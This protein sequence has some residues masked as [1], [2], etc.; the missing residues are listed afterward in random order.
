MISKISNGACGACPAGECSPPPSL[1]CAVYT[2]SQHSLQLCLIP[3]A[4]PVSAPFPHPWFVQCTLT[5]YSLLGFSVPPPAAPAPALAPTASLAPAPA[6]AP[7]AS[8]C[9]ACFEDIEPNETFVCSGPA[10]HSMCRACIE[11]NVE[12]QVQ[13]GLGLQQFLVRGCTITCMLCEGAGVTS[14]PHFDMHAIASRISKHHYDLYVH[15][16]GERSVQEA[17][18]AAAQTQPAADYVSSVLAEFFCP[19]K[20]PNCRAVFVVRNLNPMSRQCTLTHMFAAQW[21]LCCYDLPPMPSAFLPVVPQN[22]CCRQQEQ[23]RR[24]DHAQPHF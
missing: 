14:P 10:P 23:G 18:K 7:T 13:M 21:R 16:V 2:H 4:L 22:F 6:P 9:D 24:H 3:L 20:C 5:L 19:E 11:Q 17:L 12:V 1:F 15:A 8:L